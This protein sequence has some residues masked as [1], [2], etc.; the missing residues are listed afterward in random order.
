M[1]LDRL[2]EQHYSVDVRQQRHVKVDRRPSN[3]VVVLDL[4]ALGVR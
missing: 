2:D 4:L 3:K 1:L